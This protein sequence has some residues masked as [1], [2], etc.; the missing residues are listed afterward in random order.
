MF[1]KK[2]SLT[3]FRNLSALSIDFA[4]VTLFIGKNAQGKSNLLESAYFLATTKSSRA[5]KD[6]QLVQYKKNYLRVEGVV[7]SDLE[8]ETTALEIY[9]QH[10]DPGNSEVIEKRVRVNGVPRRSTD[11][12]GNLVAISFAP[13]DINLVTSSP[14]LRRWHLDLSLAQVDKT[15]KSAMNIYTQALTAKNRVLKN[16]KEGLATTDQLEFWTEQMIDSGKVITEKREHFFQVINSR[17]NG[18]LGKFTFN[19]QASEIST[20]RVTQYLSREVA[21]GQ[22]LVGPHRDDFTFQLAGQNLAFFG[23]RGEQRTAVLELKLAELLYV[24]QVKNISPIL[25]LD[26][27]FS[28]LD[29][30]HQ[31]FVIQAIGR[32]QTLISAVETENLPNQFMSSIQVFKVEEGK[33]VS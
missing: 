20:A 3:H 32:Q 19:Y 4:P 30:A 11:Y 23:S 13:E 14:S 25:L 15:Y 18:S 29:R 22:S 10:K 6:A 2:I 16:I 12:I 7:Q 28:E 21:A 8:P 1:L 33:L 9:M 31:D 26:D 17:E 27:V 5:D 24:R